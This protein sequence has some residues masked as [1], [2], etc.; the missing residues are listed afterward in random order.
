MA[1]SLQRGVGT[2]KFSVPRDGVVT[3]A[4]VAI[5]V[6][7]FDD[8]DIVV[9]EV[10]EDPRPLVVER[11]PGFRPRFC[12]NAIGPVGNTF[13]A[14]NRRRSSRRFSCSRRAT[15]SSSSASS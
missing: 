8:G 13:F 15:F 7:F 3:P 14:K 1:I 12:G 11:R 5:E 6:V 9:G 10:G 4:G 2:G